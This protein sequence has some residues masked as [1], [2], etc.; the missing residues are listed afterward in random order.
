MREVDSVFDVR[1]INPLF[2]PEMADVG[3]RSGLAT[4]CIVEIAAAV[5]DGIGVVICTALTA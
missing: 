1:K 3:A 2:L 4:L 5:I